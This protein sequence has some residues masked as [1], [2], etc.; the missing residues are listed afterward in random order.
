MC[1]SSLRIVGD[2]QGS[3]LFTGMAKV[4][5][6]GNTVSKVLFGGFRLGFGGGSG[7]ALFFKPGFDGFIL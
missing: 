7:P 4:S 1:Y 6:E 3:N 2:L 5:Q